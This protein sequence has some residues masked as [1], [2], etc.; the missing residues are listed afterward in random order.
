MFIPKKILARKCN[1]SS[2]SLDLLLDLNVFKE[3]ILVNTY[4]VTLYGIEEPNYSLNIIPWM[5][6]LNIASTDQVSFESNLSFSFADSSNNNNDPMILTINP[7]LKEIDFWDGYSKNT[8]EA[9]KSS[10]EFKSGVKNYL[11]KFKKL[12]KN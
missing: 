8:S 9:F 11:K 1:I 10:L 7:L 12:L 4:L 5:Q 2:D 6:I 3:E